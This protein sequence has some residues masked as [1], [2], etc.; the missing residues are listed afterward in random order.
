[1]LSFRNECGG[2]NCTKQLGD[3]THDSAARLT[4]RALQCGIEIIRGDREVSEG[5][6]SLGLHKAEQANR[7]GHARRARRDG[8]W[9]RLSSQRCS[10]STL[11]KQ[12]II[13]ETVRIEV[14]RKVRGRRKPEI[15]VITVRRRREN[16][17]PPVSSIEEMKQLLL[18]FQ[19]PKEPGK[20]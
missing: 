2:Q 4:H 12:V 9:G 17:D 18:G 3:T 5:A 7:Q 1:M 15:D 19:A 11:S 16:V 10:R 20:K 14:V 6:D 13:I 8:G